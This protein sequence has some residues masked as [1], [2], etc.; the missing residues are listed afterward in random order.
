L[1]KIIE[2]FR[3]V[4]PL[5][6]SFVAARKKVKKEEWARERREMKDDGKREKKMYILLTVYHNIFHPTVPITCPRW[7]TYLTLPP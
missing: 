4:A 3:G 2:Y 1:L 5:E 7:E 6:F